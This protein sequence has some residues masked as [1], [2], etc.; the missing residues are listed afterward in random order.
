ML[1]TIIILAVL[2]DLLIGDPAGYPHPV[3]IIGRFINAFECFYRKRLNSES[4]AGFLTVLSTLTSVCLCLTAIF[5]FTYLVGISEIVA[6]FILYTCIA[7]KDLRKEAIDVYIVL[8]NREAIVKARKQIGR[9]VG[10]DTSEL[11]REGIIKACVETIAENLADGVIAPLFWAIIGGLIAMYFDLNIAICAASFAMCYK[12]INTMDS[13]IGY[14]NDKYLHFGKYGAKLD[15]VANY[16]PARVTGL[17]IVIATLILRKDFNNSW[18]ILKRDRGNHTSPNAGYPE[19]AMAGALDIKLC[20]PSF[21][22]GTLVDKPYIGDA[23]R[24]INQDDIL[25][26]NRISLLTTFVFL[27]LSYAVISILS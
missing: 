24:K 22:F 18:Y 15:D 9:I 3:R 13:M 4:L 7:I 6:T 12:T 27:I 14:K 17:S 5:Y 16:I 8:A 26:A 1:F 23:N 25:L 2:L 19:S 10:R 11:S 21:Y 20:G